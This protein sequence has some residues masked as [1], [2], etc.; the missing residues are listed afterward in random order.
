M[1]SSPPF[2][3]DWL[4][5]MLAIGAALFAWWRLA[6]TAHAIA[7]RQASAFAELIAAHDKASDERLRALD[8]IMGGQR[9]ILDALTAQQDRHHEDH[10]SILVQLEKLI[11]KCERILDRSERG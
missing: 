2:F 8:A 1:G 7:E 11:G 5:L 10:R 3:D 6:A 4:G 9:K